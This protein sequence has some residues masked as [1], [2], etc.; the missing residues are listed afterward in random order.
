MLDPISLFAGIVAVSPI[1]LGAI[2]LYVRQSR[3]S[4]EA[5]MD[6]HRAEL[7]TRDA[8]L[9]GR[10]AD[11]RSLDGQLQILDARLK[12][13]QDVQIAFE[14]LR[15]LPP[16]ERRADPSLRDNPIYDIFPLA[17]AAEFYD[18]IAPFY[19]RRNTGKY[20]AT[21]VEIYQAIATFCARL[22]GAKV[23]DLGGG[24]G[25]LLHRFQQHAVN[26]L[27][28]DISRGALK[29]FEGDF[30]FYDSKTMRLLD[31]ARDTFFK[32]TEQFD[33]V[34]MSYLLSSM[35]S[36]PDFQQILNAMK[37]DSIL[38]VADNHASYVDQ[39]RFYG[40]TDVEGKNLAIAPR[41]MVP[42]E[43]RALVSNS[44]FNEV[45]YKEIAVDAKPYS[46]LHVFRKNTYPLLQQ[47]EFG[48]R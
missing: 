42:A 10:D 24:T 41:P 37:D 8:L 12:L 9:A 21:Y 46:Q 47:T 45:L 3:K 28:V 31:V 5:L 48:I 1:A 6:Q 33:V 39:N 26:W 18:S 43:I 38:I 15:Q 4:R 40:F 2:G 30:N 23:A 19:N 29:V 20:L 7:A 34:A 22:D 17:K 11:V 13:A 14:K 44:G 32:P 36:S 35:D 25:F 16:P 27:N